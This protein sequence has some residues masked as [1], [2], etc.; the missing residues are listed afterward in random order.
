VT[1]VTNDKSQP[2]ARLSRAFIA[3]CL[4]IDVVIGVAIT[5]FELYR[6]TKWQNSPPTRP[7][8]LPL[9]TIVAALIVVGIAGVAATMHQRFRFLPCALPTVMVIVTMTWFA[10]SQTLVNLAPNPCFYLNSVSVGRLAS[11]NTTTGSQDGPEWINILTDGVTIAVPSSRNAIARAVSLSAGSF[12]QLEGSLSPRL[13]QDVAVLEK[14]V[15]S[16]GTSTSERSSLAARA[17]VSALTEFAF[18]VCQD[19]G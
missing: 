19:M 8:G 6:Q 12:N 17:A 15:Q 1:D 10:T 18:N 14:I 13:K 16:P 5:D 2:R 11:F 3:T 7:L 9:W 4:S